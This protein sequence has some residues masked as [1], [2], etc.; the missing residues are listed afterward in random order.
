VNLL[1]GCASLIGYRV[2]PGV[3]WSF[4]VL[5]LYDLVLVV[6]DFIVAFSS[7]LEAVEDGTAKQI[8]VDLLPFLEDIFGDHVDNLLIDC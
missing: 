3:F 4:F 1:S 8:L 6:E 5:D 2:S 7:I